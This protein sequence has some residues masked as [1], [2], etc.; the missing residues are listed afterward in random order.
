[1]NNDVSLS[2][3]M[4]LET[5]RGTRLC[6]HVN[7]ATARNVPEVNCLMK[8]VAGRKVFVISAEMTG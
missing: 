3:V 4:R 6:S 1:M 5:E 7:V 8:E 2:A